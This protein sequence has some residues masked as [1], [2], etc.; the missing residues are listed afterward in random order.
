M[1]RNLSYS[2]TVNA[3]DRD[4]QTPTEFNISVTD[5]NEAP[6]GR[7]MLRL[8]LLMKM[9]IFLMIFNI[10]S[11]DDRDVLIYEL[12]EAPTWVTLSEGVLS[13]NSLKRRRWC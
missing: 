7:I 1:R 3:S 6:R 5:V 12:I 2:V 9:Q 8:L 10:A 11:D 4:L 13:R